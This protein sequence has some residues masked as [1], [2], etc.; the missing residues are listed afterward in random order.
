MSGVVLAGGASSRM[1]T[2][3]ALLK[4][5]GRPLIEGVIGTLK[6][7]FREVAIV[8]NDPAAYAGLGV[9]IWP[10]A[11][12]GKGALGGIY[13]A[14]S[15]SAFAQI[16]CIACDMP[17]PSPA[18]ISLLAGLAPGY[19][20]V[21]PKTGSG[22]EPLHAVYGKSCLPSIRTMLSEGRL[23]VDL[24]F[25]G[26]RSRVVEEAELRALDSDLR[27]F[28]NV[29]TQEELLAAARLAAPGEAEGM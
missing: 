9:P 25:P 3:K 19:D 28:L 20:V 17:F 22:Y 15:R 6:P 7:L 21:V 18:V 13:T 8:A 26:V 10:D 5:R 11:V 29:N 27:C 16:F 4:V 23:K 2:N 1:G 12:T 14:L 24:L